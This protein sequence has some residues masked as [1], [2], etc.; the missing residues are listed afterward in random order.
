MTSILEKFNL[1]SRTA[2]VLFIISINTSCVNKKTDY[3]ALKPKRVYNKN[4][5]S[6]I[7]GEKPIQFE[8]KEGILLFNRSGYKEDFF[9]LAPHFAGQEYGTT[10]GPSSLRL[11]LSVLYIKLDKNFLIDPEKTLL[12]KQ[13]G[14]YG[15]KFQMSERNSMSCYIQK[16]KIEY[17][18]IAR[19]KKNSQGYYS[20]GIDMK[21]L[22]KAF[23]CHDSRI[24]VEQKT[25]KS[26]NKAGLQAFKEDI[27]KTL[28]NDSQYIIVNYHLGI[29]RE[30][31]SGH[32]SP[33]VAYDELT[34]RVLIMNVATHIGGWNWVKVFDLYAS[35]NSVINGNDRGYL[36]VKVL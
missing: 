9:R 1:W 2:L 16:G 20:G 17:D 13:N 31:S 22:A 23:E 4:S 34:D 25:M 7:S 36:I 15:P 30:I 33:I 24:K 12:P 14:I 11:I 35:M 21:D 27:K 32:H 29:E 19:Q 3:N 18:I 6:F 8:S 10:C 5:E 26:T 28:N